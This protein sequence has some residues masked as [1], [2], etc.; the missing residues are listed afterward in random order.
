MAL[1]AQL[2]SANT[3]VR[4]VVA[5]QSSINTGLLGDRYT[6]VETFTNG[7][8]GLYAGVG[9]TYN[10]LNDSFSTAALDL[11]VITSNDPRIDISD[12]WTVAERSNLK[13]NANRPANDSTVNFK[14]C[15]P[16]MRLRFNTN[17]TSIKLGVRYTKQT[18]HGAFNSTAEV[19]VD[20]VS[21]TTFNA[22]N[23]AAHNSAAASKE[24]TITLG[25]ASNRLVELIWPYGDTMDFLYLKVSS[26]ATITAPTARPTSKICLV[27]DSITQGFSVAKPSDTYAFKLGN[28]KNRQICNLGYGGRT[29]VGSD[30]LLVDPTCGSVVI[31]HGYNDFAAQYSLDS[32]QSAYQSLLQN[33]RTTSPSA[34]IYAVSPVY[35]TTS[36]TIPLSSY[37]TRVAAAVTSV[38]DENTMYIDGLTVMANNGGRLSDG[39]HPNAAGTTDIATVLHSLII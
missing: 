32:F 16:N 26:G 24:V 20:G 34:K 19:F 39:V 22:T 3:A 6:F 35:S 4:T 30:G 14:L 18:G 17:A 29:A 37:R 1:F 2:N 25:A 13:L 38:G 36:L 23:N 11:P 12:Y 33:I 31:L 10:P 15:N 21:N 5:D 9:R 28:L 8:R 7:S 27:G